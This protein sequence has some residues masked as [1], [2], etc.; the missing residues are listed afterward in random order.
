MKSTFIWIIGFIAIIWTVEAINTV[1]GHRL[2]SWGILPRTTQGLR[3]IPLSL[4]IH[5]S[6][7]H[8][9]SNTVPLVLLGG[10]VAL[11]GRR[12][13][14]EV[15]IVII[16]I[17][18]FA[19]WIFARS[20]FHIGASGLVFGYF[21]YLVSRGLWDRSI[22]SLLIA[23]LALV[24]YGGILFGVVP[25]QDFIS[26]EGHL[27]GLVAGILAARFNAANRRRLPLLSDK[28]IP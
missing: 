12:V 7:S 13:L 19:V 9:I 15:S 27:F 8:V 21:G 11:K 2:D 24:L 6:F 16:V 5:G 23:G 4:F 3:G 18:G 20:A 1:S 10:L 22:A 14:I 26:W 25:T 17:S 28:R